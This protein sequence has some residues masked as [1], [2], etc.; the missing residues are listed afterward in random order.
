MKNILV[1]LAIVFS[2]VASAGILIEPQLGYVLSNKFAGTMTYSGPASGSMAIDEKTT[3]V[4]YGARLGY[5]MLGFMTGLNYGHL[6]GKSTD[7]TDG[8]KD[9]VKGTN[10]GV[11]VGYNAPV[12]FRAW[13]AYNFS[14]KSEIST[15]TFKG[16]S[17]EV[18]LGF[19]GMPFLSINFIYRMYDFTKMNSNS[20]DFTVSNFKPKEMELAVSAPFNLF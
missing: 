10:L 11:F 19:K 13:L 18:G 6:S 1:L 2:S 3:G 5:S 8:S 17:T 16:S 12:L 4:G 15:S 14:A 9:D 7:N 20:M